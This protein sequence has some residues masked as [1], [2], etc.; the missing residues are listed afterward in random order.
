MSRSVRRRI[1]KWLGMRWVWFSHKEYHERDAFEYL[2]LRV[3]RFWVISYYKGGVTIWKAN[4][5]DFHDADS[6]ID[7]NRTVQVRDYILSGKYSHEEVEKYPYP[8]P[9]KAS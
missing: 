3:L 9:D 2:G 5:L 8:A 1:P 7:I 6:M 4:R